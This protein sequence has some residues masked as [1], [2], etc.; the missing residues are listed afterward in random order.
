MKIKKTSLIDLKKIFDIKKESMSNGAWWWWF[1]LFFFENPKNP[2][3]PQQLMI[4]WST[5]NAGDMTCNNLKF[6]LNPSLEDNAI[7]GIVASWYFDGEKMHHPLILERCNIKILDNQL[8]TDST[9]PTFFSVNKNK[10]LIKIGNDFELTAKLE[11]K[12][13]FKKPVYHSNIYVGNKGYSM[14][15]L[16]HTKLS[17][18]IKNKPINGSAFFHRIFVNTPTPS[19]YWGLFHFENGGILTYFNP[20]LFGKSLKKDIT[21]FDGKEI[22]E[23]VDINVNKKDKNSNIFIVSGENDFER[24]NFIVNSYSRSSWTLK[25][26]SFGIIPSKMIYNEY[27]STVSDF[28]LI[29]KKT[30]E[31]ITLEDLGKSVGNTEHTT[32]FL[33]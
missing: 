19:W 24:I 11:N 15:R 9:I 21:F 12:H 20:H 30:G 16:I 3:K 13:N 23:F 29:N 8:L 33:I 4:L 22:H 32:G 17:G 5:K 14:I 31:K 18:R 6:K 27:P 1:W 7:K 28:K 10:S 2:E 25:K 26:K